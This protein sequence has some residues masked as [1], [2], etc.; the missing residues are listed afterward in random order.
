[1]K[2]LAD[3]SLPEADE[4]SNPGCPRAPEPSQAQERSSQCVPMVTGICDDCT[5]EII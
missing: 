2:A 5:N 3:M 4:T 1:M